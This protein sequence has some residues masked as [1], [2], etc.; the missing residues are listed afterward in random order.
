MSER[1]ESDLASY[2]K[3][4]LKHRQMILVVFVL[5]VV[6][7]GVVSL[8][9]P[10]VYRGVVKLKSVATSAA[11]SSLPYTTKA[12][13]SLATSD[14]TVQDV[15]EELRETGLAAGVSTAQLRRM[16]SIERIEGLTLFELHVDSR[17]PKLAAAAANLLAKGFVEATQ[18]YVSQSQEGR[19]EAVEKAFASAEQRWREAHQA[20][21]EFEKKHLVKSAPY[22]GAG[23][24]RTLSVFEERIAAQSQEIEEYRTAEARIDVLITELDAFLERTGEGGGVDVGSATLFLGS[25]YVRSL[26]ILGESALAPS[27]LLDPGYWMKDKTRVLGA[28][29]DL[30]IRL[31]ARKAVLEQRRKAVDETFAAL[32]LEG[33]KLARELDELSRNANEAEAELSTL[34]KQVSNTALSVLMLSAS[35][36]VTIMAEASEP[37]RAVFPRRTLNVVVAGCFGLA[38][39]IGLAFIKE[40]LAQALASARR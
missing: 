7:S 5:S 31:Q 18:R 8:M 10:K 30:R 2:L 13:K 17:D 35:P 27:G 38:V 26:G 33:A 14:N 29:R 1:T 40:A 37:T 22:F 25:V 20:L 28:L 32:T 9:L 16:V 6:G 24:T 12:Y 39:G 23:Q 19:Q 34:R 3:V 4:I 21:G 36:P 15:L 11:D